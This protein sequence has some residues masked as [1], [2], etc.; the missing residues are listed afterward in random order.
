M[1]LGRLP[2]GVGSLGARGE[3]SG[4]LPASLHA[5]HRTA[6]PKSCCSVQEYPQARAVRC[7]SRA[8]QQRG[9]CPRYEAAFPQ[10]ACDSTP[11]SS[12]A[13]SLGDIGLALLTDLARRMLG[14]YIF[15]D[16]SCVWMTGQYGIAQCHAHASWK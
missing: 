15:A 8:L 3:A 10:H 5:H 13:S 16:D 14:D 4:R 12:P 9:H 6:L 2:H 7:S 11:P 1:A